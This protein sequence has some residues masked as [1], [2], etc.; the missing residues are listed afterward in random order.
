M[1]ANN[2]IFTLQVNWTYGYARSRNVV[3]KKRTKSY[4]FVFEGDV[5][6]WGEL[7]RTGKLKKSAM[8]QLLTCPTA[9]QR[10]MPDQASAAAY[11]SMLHDECFP[12]Y[13]LMALSVTYHSK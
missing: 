4:F 6:M 1:S 7:T 8:W 12:E 11:A 5:D 3:T 9:R 2:A 13:G 10:Q